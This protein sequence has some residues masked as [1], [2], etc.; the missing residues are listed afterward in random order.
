M[1]VVLSALAWAD[2]RPDAPPGEAAAVLADLDARA[3]SVP[4]LRYGVVRTT[5]ENDVK[6][7][8]RWRYATDEGRFRIDY[9]GDTQR[10]VICDGALL[11]DYVPVLREAMQYDLTRMDLPEAQAVMGRIL[12]H[13]AVPGFRAGA[14][15][16]WAWSWEAEPQQIGDVWGWEAVG[17]DGHG[18]E[19]RFVVADDG[20]RLYRSNIRQHGDFVVSVEA[21]D[22]LEIASGVWFPQR[23]EMQAPGEGGLID[24]ELRVQGIKAEAVPAS[25]FD[26]KLDDSIELNRVP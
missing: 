7:E 6:Q 20:S 15:P 23:V 22:H 13:V 18:G 24:V 4:A 25:T 14:D 10:V 12:E 26:T 1:L 16:T 11:V 9:S 19:L 3:A 8:E 5:E 21:R 2:A 17:T